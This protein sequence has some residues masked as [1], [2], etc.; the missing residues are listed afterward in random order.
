M[1]RITDTA[2]KLQ[3][4]DCEKHYPHE[5]CGLLVGPAPKDRHSIRITEAHVVPNL[6][7]ERAHDR[8]VLDPR[9]FDQI[10]REIR[11]RGL[12]VVGIY[13]SHPDHPAE[14]SAFD[15]AR[16]QE[17]VEAFGDNSWVYFIASIVKGKLEICRAWVLNAQHEAFVESELAIGE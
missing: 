5:A 2:W 13:H 8:F 6:N 12:E 7:T 3:I 16:A 15:L 17:V 4:A 9:T 1:T 14:P 11:K 10:D